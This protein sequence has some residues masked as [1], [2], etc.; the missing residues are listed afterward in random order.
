VARHPITDIKGVGPA[1]AKA[2]HRLGIDT[3]EDAVYYLPRDYRDLSHT[4]T[5]AGARHGDEVVLVARVC[6]KP[7]THRPKR[8]L[9]IVKATVEDA[10]G[11]CVCVWYNQPWI[12]ETMARD[13]Q[14]VFFGRVEARFGEE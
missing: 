7:V 14:W 9:T 3:V 4:D 5:V 12:A 8:N 13:T 1:R 11:R 2:L 10:T 6:A